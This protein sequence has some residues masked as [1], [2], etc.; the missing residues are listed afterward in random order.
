M[1]QS[2]LK[3][4]PKQDLPDIPSTSSD[5]PNQE[6]DKVQTAEEVQEHGD[7]STPT[8]PTTPPLQ[9]LPASDDVPAS[10][11]LESG[12]SKGSQYTLVAR[13]YS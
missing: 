9:S 11:P 7:P 3:Y 2:W 10:V 6:S 12:L 5:I 13:F 1:L 8:M 4:K